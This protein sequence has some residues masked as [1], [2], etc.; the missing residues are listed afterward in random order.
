M[1][2]TSLL[3]VDP[4]QTHR[5][6]TAS[7]L[8]SAFPGGT[9]S[10]AASY[11]SAVQMLSA[12]IDAVVTRY[13]IRDSTG[14]E[15]VAFVRENWP[16]TD[17]FL[18]AETTDIETESFEETVV[19]FVPKETTDALETLVALIKQADVANGQR[20]Y[21]LPPCDRERVA[22]VASHTDDVE[23][24][25]ETLAQLTT[26]AVDHFG[27]RTAAVS[28]IEDRTQHVLTQQGP[29]TLPARRAESVNTYTLAHD[30]ATMAVPDL[31]EDPRFETE[32]GPVSYLGAQIAT[33]D[34]YVIGVL[35][36]FDDTPRTFTSAERDHL[37]TLASL[38]SDVLSL[39]RRHLDADSDDRLDTTE[40]QDE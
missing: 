20:E 34:G 1:L 2:E 21:P 39:N 6:E 29:H 22:R 14:V 27:V 40:D 17:C 38:A 33:A 16:G 9:V 32:G 8:E 5:E 25:R 26:L 7:A 19:E 30:E 12:D 15:L 10:T 35:S 28:V 18:Y 24:V 4:D 31:R 37:E 36:L 11:E 13:H 3:L 23:A